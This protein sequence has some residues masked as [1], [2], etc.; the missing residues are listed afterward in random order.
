MWQNYTLE[1]ASD[2]MIWGLYT[3]SQFLDIV[4]PEVTS[5]RG[6]LKKTKQKIGSYNVSTFQCLISGTVSYGEF[7]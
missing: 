4:I 5:V 3:L 6:L 1:R 2:F 7:V